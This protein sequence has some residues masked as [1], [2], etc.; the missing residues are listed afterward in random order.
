M[1]AWTLPLKVAYSTLISCIFVL[2]AIVGYALRFQVTKISFW[3]LGLYGT[4]VLAFIVLQLVFA[5]LNRVLVRRWRRRAPTPVSR[6]WD[7]EK[8]QPGDR[9]ASKLGLAVVGYREE[10]AL[11]AA[12]LESIQQLDYPDRIVLCV[13]IDGDED[14]DKDMAAV[15]AK[16]FP[17]QPIVTLP[18]LLSDN[19][20]NSSIPSSSSSSSNPPNSSKATN[21]LNATTNS[22]KT[23]TSPSNTTTNSS[24]TTPNSTEKTLPAFVSV[25]PSDTQ[26]VCYLQPHRGKRHA[27]Y[28]AFRVLLAAG[29]DAIVSTDSDTRFNRRAAL[30]LERALFFFP[31]IGAAAGDVRIWN[32]SDSLLSFMSSLRYWMAFNIER[33]AQSFNRAVT[34]VSGPM[35]IYR[36]RVIENLLDAWVHQTFLGLE[37]TYGDDRHLTNC[38]LARGHAVVYTHH[39]F[40]ETETPTSFFRWFR[41]QTRWSKSFYREMLWNA[42]SLHKHSPWMAAELFYQGMYPFV[43]MYSIFYILYA[44]TSWVLLMWL[45]SLSAMTMVKTIYAI[46]VARSARFLA[47]PLYALYYLFGLVPAKLW[48]IISLWDVGWGTS[49]RSASE[50]K[51]EAVLWLQIKQAM[52]VVIW[53]AMLLAG[54]CFNVIYFVRDPYVGPY[55]IPTDDPRSIVFYQNPGS[56]FIEQ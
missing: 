51:R 54:V 7:D 1:V 17:N 21:S 28:T 42:R 29:C 23:T 55:A 12:C 27:M 31:G 49:A 38:V 41:Q 53:T 8:L 32:A 18:R 35:G 37:C 13:V 11:F 52:P 25:L 19:D 43:L 45:T 56:A 40:C 33:A 4:I 14:E 39:A 6:H 5:T 26:V 9:R 50:R 30:E 16:V 3:V 48:A 36:A 34:C 20:C 22:P 46:I 47:F 15:F 44:K 10:T 24:K 2:P